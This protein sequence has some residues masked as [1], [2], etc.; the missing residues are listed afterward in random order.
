MEEQGFLN[1]GG[2]HMAAHEHDHS[3]LLHS[4]RNVGADHYGDWR[5]EPVRFASGP[6]ARAHQAPCLALRMCRV[7]NEVVPA[8]ADRA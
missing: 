3:Y 1:D 7:R 6:K 4:H 5:A 2:E 8:I